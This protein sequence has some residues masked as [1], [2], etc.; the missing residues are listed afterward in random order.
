MNSSY[1][2]E[3]DFYNVNKYAQYAITMRIHINLN[4]NNILEYAI[5]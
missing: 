5:C 4:W 3:N 1:I 2:L